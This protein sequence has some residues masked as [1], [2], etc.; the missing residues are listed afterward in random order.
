MF[1]KALFLFGWRTNHNGT[2]AIQTP[3]R[4]VEFSLRRFFHSF[5]VLCN[6]LAFSACGGSRRVLTANLVQFGSLSVEYFSMARN[7]SEAS[8]APCWR[9]SPERITRPPAVSHERQK[10]MH[11][12]RPRVGQPHRPA[13]RRPE[14]TRRA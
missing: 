14:P 9:V 1:S 4:C 2:L 10:L 6:L 3:E 12:L 11:L 13:P 8:T 7:A 5:L